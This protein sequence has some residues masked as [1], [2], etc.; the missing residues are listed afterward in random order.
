M[1][2]WWDLQLAV[3]IS[4]SLRGTATE[5]SWCHLR[6]GRPT[7]MT[8]TR[9]RAIGSDC[10]RCR[11]IV[12]YLTLISPLSFCTTALHAAAPLFLIVDSHCGSWQPPIALPLTSLPLA[13]AH[14][15]TTSQRMASLHFSSPPLLARGED[16]SATRI[17][18]SRG[19]LCREDPSISRIS[20][21]LASSGCE[22]LPDQPRHAPLLDA[23]LPRGVGPR[24]LQPALRRD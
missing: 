19:S 14:H 7:H 5:G 2:L 20:R 9:L 24:P 21:P 4:S 3:R 11:T 17:P 1:G 16:P 10:D 13:T 15:T 23:P 6:D 22:D 12:K 8:A 18:L